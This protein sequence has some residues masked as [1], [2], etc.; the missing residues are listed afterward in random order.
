MCNDNFQVGQKV[1]FAGQDEKH[2]SG[3]YTVRNVWPMQNEM[4]IVHAGGGSVIV[5]CDAE[6]V[7]PRV[8]DHQAI[9]NQAYAR[10]TTGWSKEQFWAQLNEREQ[11]A[12]FVGNLNYQVENGG[13]S[14]WCFNA[15][16]DC[17][18]PLESLL[19]EKIGTET[20]LKVAEMVNTVASAH[21]ERESEEQ[22]TPDNAYCCCDPDEDCNCESEDDVREAAYEGF[23]SVAEPLN[24]AFYALGAQLLQDTADYLAGRELVKV[25]PVVDKADTKDQLTKIRCQLVGRDGNAF[26]I[27][28]F[29]SQALREGGRRDLIE[30]FRTEAMSG[31]YDHLL[32]TAMRYVDV[33]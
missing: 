16:V 9:M 11:V 23:Q 29:V 25:E 19:R 7:E 30:P 6:A 24:D 18:G 8:E 31:D 17:A 13:W 20:A 2:P 33:Y 22:R 3:V 12:V 4:E 14:Q 15:Y 5:S 21:E 10:W 27:I 28:G 32:Q 1:Q 26:S